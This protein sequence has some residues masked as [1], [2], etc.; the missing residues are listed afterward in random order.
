MA[1]ITVIEDPL[2]RFDEGISFEAWEGY[3]QVYTTE[4]TRTSWSPRAA[5]AIAAVFSHM[6]D[7]AMRG[8]Q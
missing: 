7:E 2:G 6:A 3:V 5:R 4:D 8:N 1:R